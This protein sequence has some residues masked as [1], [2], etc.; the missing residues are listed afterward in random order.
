MVEW[1]RAQ[2][3]RQA[4]VDPSAQRF[5]PELQAS[6]SGISEGEGSDKNGSE[7]PL[8]QGGVAVAAVGGGLAGGAA[9]SGSGQA[10]LQGLS[11]AEIR[12]RIKQRRQA[13]LQQQGSQ[14]LQGAAEEQSM[15]GRGHAGKASGGKQTSRGSNLHAFGGREKGRKGK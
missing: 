10:G 2:L 14:T 4:D 13:L 11:D 5:G 6:G 8:Q 1:Q 15:S 12:L 3:I 7:E 9:G